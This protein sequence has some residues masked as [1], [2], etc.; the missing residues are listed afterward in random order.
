MHHGSS[1]NVYGIELKLF[2]A[3]LEPWILTSRLFC[4][5]YIKEQTVLVLMPNLF[6][7]LPSASLTS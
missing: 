7:P 5:A 1:V 6:R 2:L 3:N 4:L